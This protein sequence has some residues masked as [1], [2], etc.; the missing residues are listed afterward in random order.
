VLN[1]ASL[2]PTFLATSASRRV[3]TQLYGDCRK[4]LQQFAT[5]SKPFS[6]GPARRF[7]HVRRHTPDRAAADPRLSPRSGRPR[8]T[9][10]AG[11]L[12]SI[13]CVAK[14]LSFKK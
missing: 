7:A 10:A 6:G 12:L 14:S 5:R 11:S 8:R 4:K 13:F 1:V 9:P 2:T 3:M